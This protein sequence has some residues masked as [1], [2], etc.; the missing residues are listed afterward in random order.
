MERRVVRVHPDDNVAIVADDDGAPAGSTFAGGLVAIE[1]IP[2]AHKIALR[3]I[4]A[5]DPVI[6]YGQPIGTARRSIGRGALVGGDLV[7]VPEAPDLDALRVPP[8]PPAA[9]APLD[10]YSFEGYRN[11]D[12]TVGTRNVLGLMPTVQCI[13]PTVE[14]AAARIRAEILPRYPGVDGLV[15]LAHDWG[16]GIAIDAPGAALPTRTLANIARN[17]NLGGGPLLVCLGC[18]KLTPERLGLVSIDD[19]I[20]M[21]DDHRRGFSGTVAAIMQAA[22]R[23]LESLSRRQRVSCPAS[24]LVVGLQCGGSDAFSGVTANPAVGFAADLLVRCGATVLLSEV[25]EV[26]DALHI[27]SR[28]A[29]DPEVVDALVREMRWYDE[30]LRAG[31]ADRTANPAPGNLHGGLTNI[32]EKTLGAIAKAGSSPLTGVLSHGERVSRRGLLFA[33]TPAGDFHCGTL[34][35]AAGMNLHVFTTGEGS[36]YGLALAPV[37]KVA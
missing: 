18:E 16:C 27:L 26:R 3:D 15:V 29:A 21:Q 32:V 37:V 11:D 4:A 6:R 19:T 17:P 25:T 7:A 30:Y 28:R 5:G 35:L 23:R 34:Q 22:E 8:S 24:D 36:P 13:A 2:H 9:P 20:T 1:D 10:G 14:H 12:G 33:A 31:G